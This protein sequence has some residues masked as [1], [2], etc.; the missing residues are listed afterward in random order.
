MSLRSVLRVALS[1]ATK[2]IRAVGT[3]VR[4]AALPAVFVTRAV[5]DTAT[6]AIRFVRELVAPTPPVSAAEAQADAYLDAAAGEPDAFASEPAPLSMAERFPE[7]DYLRNWCRHAIGS[8]G[9]GPVDESVLPDRILLWLH[10]LDVGNLHRVAVAPLST[11]DRH[12]RA[13]SV[14]ELMTNMPPVLTDREARAAAEARRDAV[15]ASL[16]RA[17]CA[18]RA[19]ETVDEFL[20]DLHEHAISEAGPAPRPFR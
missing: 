18:E 15:I 8:P 5:V 2:A 7:A 10:S 3:S 16:A 4:Y 14:N 6:G 17:S 9:V 20:H 13:K 1:A 12:L 19:A 11:L